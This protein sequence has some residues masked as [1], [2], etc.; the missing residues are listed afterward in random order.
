MSFDPK[1]A[2][3]SK[4]VSAEAVGGSSTRTQPSFAKKNMSFGSISELKT[5]IVLDCFGYLNFQFRKK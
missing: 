4:D 5:M 3:Q 1:Q 2:L